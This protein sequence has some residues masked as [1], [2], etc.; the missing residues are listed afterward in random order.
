MELPINKKNTIHPSFSSHN[1][2]FLTLK[3]NGKKEEEVKNVHFYIM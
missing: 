3:K 2:K 1:G